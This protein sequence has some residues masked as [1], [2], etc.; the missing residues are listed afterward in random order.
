MAKPHYMKSKS[1]S[2]AEL[3]PH[4]ATRRTMPTAEQ[5]AGALRAELKLAA[6]IAESRR[7]QEARKYSA[8]LLIVLLRN[9]MWPRTKEFNN[10]MDELCRLWAEL[11]AKSKRP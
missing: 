5:K 9:D 7:R 11:K 2:P 1:G 4:R 6:T 3:G 10:E 8:N